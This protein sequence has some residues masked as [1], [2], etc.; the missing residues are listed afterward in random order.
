M[1]MYLAAQAAQGG[2]CGAEQVLNQL[3]QPIFFVPGWQTLDPLQ[4]RIDP[5][6]MPYGGAVFTIVRLADFICLGAFDSPTLVYH[7]HMEPF[8]NNAP[9]MRL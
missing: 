1:V 2:C 8:S 5:V 7:L 6:L 3:A 9:C 4:E